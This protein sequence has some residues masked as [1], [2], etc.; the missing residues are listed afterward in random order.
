MIFQHGSI[1]LYSTN[2]GREMGNS[3]EDL[4]IR[5]SYDEAMIKLKA[6][7]KKT[8]SVQLNTSSLNEK[9]NKHLKQLLQN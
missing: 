8:F 6:S 3:L 7:F 4:G 1:S 9:E 2:E 5:L